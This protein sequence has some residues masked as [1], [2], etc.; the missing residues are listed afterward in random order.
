MQKYI[1][2]LTEDDFP[3]FL[4]MDTG[5]EDDYIAHFFQRFVHAG[6]SLYGLFAEDQLAVM[7]GFSV[8]AGSYAML[9]KLRSDRRFQGKSLAT[10]LM[11]YVKNEALQ[12]KE[13]KW[14]GGNTEEKN[15][16]ARRVL[17]KS[18]LTPRITQYAATAASVF[19]LETGAGSWKKVTSLKKKQQWLENTYLK[20]NKIFPYECYYPFPAAPSLFGKEELQSWNMYENEA[21][22][23]FVI[24]KHDQKRTHYVHVGYPWDDFHRQ[25]GFWETISAAQ[26]ELEEKLQEKP[27]IWLDLPK[28]AAGSLPPGHPFNLSS[29]WVLH[30]AHR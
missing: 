24:T 29:I 9:G 21:G 6:D 27:I 13:V 4:A 7:A 5:I 1:R 18:G 10:E 23:R 22:T 16:P 8:F 17:E 3:L 15:L 25:P 2:R 12:R 28:E 26:Q 20:E 19:P 11:T 14:V 30:E